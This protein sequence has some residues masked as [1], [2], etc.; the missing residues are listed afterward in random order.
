MAVS[1]HQEVIDCSRAAGF[2]WGKTDA[3]AGLAGASSCSGDLK[4][5]AA[6]YA[7][8]LDRA[9][10]MSFTHLVASSLLGLAGVAVSGQPM[11]GA[12]LLGAAEG[13]ITSLGALLFPRDQP[14]R[15]R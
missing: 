7:E 11:T 3:R 2:G 13:L 14:T 12:R 4:L 1:S 6:L 9:S 15:E 10:D 5:A 8:S